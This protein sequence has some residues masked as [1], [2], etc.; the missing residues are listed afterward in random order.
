MRQVELEDE[1]RP[2]FIA[3]EFSRPAPGNAL[4][5]EYPVRLPVLTFAR[6]D[7]EDHQSRHAYVAADVLLYAHL[8]VNV[9]DLVGRVKPVPGAAAERGEGG[10]GGGWRGWIVVTV[11]NARVV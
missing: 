6:T 4:V 7:V 2:E 9:G 11:H 10:D 3:E 8:E 1:R 5:D